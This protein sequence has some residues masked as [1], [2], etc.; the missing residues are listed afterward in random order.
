MEPGYQPA[1]LPYYYIGNGDN[2]YGYMVGNGAHDDGA[3]L[4]GTSQ[5]F[6][7]S[8][9]YS[10]SNSDGHMLVDSSDTDKGDSGGPFYTWDG[11]ALTVHG[12]LSGTRFEWAAHSKYTSVQYHLGRVLNAMGLASYA[13]TD[14]P[15]NDYNA[16]WDAGV[17]DCQIHCAQDAACRAYT[18]VPNDPANPDGPG[19]C[20]MKNT[21]FGSSNAAPGMTSG[22]NYGTGFCWPSGGFCRI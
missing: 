16:F 19:A 5:R 10:S 4:A 22:P 14:M 17:A 2:S 12:D 7:I 13:N 8:K 9:V 20:W 11:S 6:L 18:H 1:V 21:Y 15:G 3:V